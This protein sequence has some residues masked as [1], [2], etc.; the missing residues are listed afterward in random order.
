[1]RVRQRRYCFP[2]NYS[3]KNY[4]HQDL[5][6]EWSKN[7]ACVRCGGLLVPSFFLDIFDASGHQW[8]L[9]WRCLSC[10]AVIDP[11]ILQNRRMAKGD[12]RHAGKKRQD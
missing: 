7:T 11:T 9:S 12:H 5:Q 3:Q 6:Q 1:M 10:G 4:N 2:Y 8:C